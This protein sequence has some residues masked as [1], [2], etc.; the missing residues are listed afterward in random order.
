MINLIIAPIS[1]SKGNVGSMRLQY[2]VNELRKNRELSIT[3]LILHRHANE[4]DKSYY[5]TDVSYLKIINY[6]LFSCVP[7][8]LTI[9]RLLKGKK[10]AGKNILYYYDIYYNPLDIFLL[11]L[12]KS[13]GYKVVLDEIELYHTK[14]F[15]SKENN[16]FKILIISIN[17]ITIKFVANHVFCIS[18]RIFD[19]FKRKS[20]L[21]TIS[22]DT[23]L[24]SL[25]SHKLHNKI[26]ILYSGSFAEKDNVLSLLSAVNKIRKSCSEFIVY[27]TGK[28]PEKTKISLINVIQKFKIENYI[29]LTGFLSSI[30]YQQLLVN[31]DICVVPRT[32][33][34]FANAGFPFKLGEYLSAGKA[35]IASNTGD[36]AKYLTEED[37]LFI[38][39]LNNYE[40]ENALVSLISNKNLRDKLSYNGKQRAIEHFNPIKQSK[41][42]ID[43]FN[44]L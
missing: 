20:S 13:I 43:I 40:L 10:I 39:P 5:N 33:S 15:N 31:S 28:C 1:I 34:N 22:Y 44:S 37:V 27:L 25:K 8:L 24:L 26:S 32:N 14:L 19:F 11:L 41:N 30:E 36:I 3:N 29:I 42:M 17:Q 21:L 12:A 9:L 16:F 2:L 35:V 7:N 6:K 18:Y 4:I 23:K 38:N